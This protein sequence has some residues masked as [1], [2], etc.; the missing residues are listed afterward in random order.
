MV[1][2]E[3]YRDLAQDYQEVRERVF[4]KYLLLDK[5]IGRAEPLANIVYVSYPVYVQSYLIAEIMSWQIHQ[6]LKDRFGSDYVFDRRVGDFLIEHLCAQG[7]FCPWKH[8]LSKVTGKEFD[9]NG[10]F[11]SHDII[12]VK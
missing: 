12:A 1:E 9:I 7:M 5:H 3:F 2:I 11:E 8:R 10:Y 6:A 4:K